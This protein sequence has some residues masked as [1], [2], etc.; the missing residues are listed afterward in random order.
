M[1]AAPV[2][3]EARYL[4]EW[5]AHH[6]ALGVSVFLLGDNG[7]SDET[8]SLLE[9]LERARL[10]VRTDWRSA[11]R[12]QLAFNAQ[13]LSIS[14]AASADGLFL[15]DVDEFLRPMTGTESILDA[16]QPW[17]SDKTVS[18]VALNWAVFGSSGHIAGDN[19]LV[20][21]RFVSRADKEFPTNRHAKAFVKPSRASGP[22][23]NP[24][25]VEITSGRY[26]ASDG[27]DVVW[28]TSVARVG[29]SARV[30]WDRLRVDH[31]V[32]KSAEEF[33]RKRARGSVMSV[34]T[35]TQRAS[36]EYFHAHDRNEV[37]DPMS[38]VFLQ[39]MSAAKAEI[40]AALANL[41]PSA[42]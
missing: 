36:D 29:V 24:H 39:R 38:D 18:A 33:E 6:R 35:E 37:L 3:D 23:E 12:F 25:A 13:A 31:F 32:L 22:C 2:R 1:I 40:E 34:L 14:K 5:L 20:T 9:R 11:T 4:I 42:V 17:L 27:S 10:I 26:V 15:I 19:R 30:I 41:P 16:C 7:G 8:S 21:E 28:D